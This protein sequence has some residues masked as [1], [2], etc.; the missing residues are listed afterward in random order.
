V[1]VPDLVRIHEAWIAHHVAAVG[2]IDRQ[3]GAAPVLDG[4][5]A[6]VVE[7]TGGRAVVTTREQPLEALQKS[8]IDRECVGECPVLGARLLDDDPPVPFQDRGGDLA[9]VIVN[10]RFD[11]LFAGENAGAGLAHAGRAQRIGGT[12]KAERRLRTLSAFEERPRRPLRLKWPSIDPAVNQ[13]KR[14]PR[15]PGAARKQ[16][17]ERSPDVHPLHSP[18]RRVPFFEGL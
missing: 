10:E 14:R 1:H 5:C 17:L 7:L 12:R 13:L 9:D 4:G 3:H 18:A 6:V 15:Q 2:Q 11:R 16:Q 8:R